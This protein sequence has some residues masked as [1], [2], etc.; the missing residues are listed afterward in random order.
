M[1]DAFLILGRTVDALR[2]SKAPSLKKW[3]HL[4][5]DP[6]LDMVPLAK[7]CVFLT[8]DKYDAI[9]GSFA[10]QTPDQPEVEPWDIENLL[11]PVLLIPRHY[12][13][14]IATMEDDQV[15]TLAKKMC[16]LPELK[17]YKID[18]SDMSERLGRYREFAAQCLKK[19]KSMLLLLTT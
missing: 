16:A 7:L 10:N 19:K 5:V 9:I 1:S 11:N 18:P 12:I 8:G 2:I 3:P 13:S 17:F 14:A 6:V 4:Q 15:T